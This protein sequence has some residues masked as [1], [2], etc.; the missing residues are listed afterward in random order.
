ML[1]EADGTPCCANSRGEVEAGPQYSG[2]EGVQKREWCLEK[3][4]VLWE[5]EKGVYQSPELGHC[6]ECPDVVG[7]PRTKAGRVM[8]VQDSAGEALDGW[9]CWVCYWC[10]L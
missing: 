8:W 7:D 3:A 2:C 1:K 4:F 10:D 6:G 9:V 5:S